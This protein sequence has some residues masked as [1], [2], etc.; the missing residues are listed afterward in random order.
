VKSEQNLAGQQNAAGQTKQQRWRLALYIFCVF[1]GGG[2]LFGGVMAFFSPEFMGEPY[3]LPLLQKIPFVGA[4][5]DS[6]VI[7]ATALLTC[8]FLPHAVAIILLLR[9]HH[10][11][12][13]SAIVCG[14]LV[15]AFTAVE[16]VFM[17]NLVSAFYLLLGAIETAVAAIC[18]RQA[19][20]DK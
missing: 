5:I 4:L 20:R 9:K 6:L 16:M 18:L 10:Y 17:L 15:V 13:M 1:M 11:Q 14:T 12:Y 2:A 19:E 3:I 7:P 8:I